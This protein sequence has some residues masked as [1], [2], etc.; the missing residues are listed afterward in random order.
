[1]SLDDIVVVPFSSYLWIVHK[2]TN[3]LLYDTSFRKKEGSILYWESYAYWS[4]TSMR[5]VFSKQ[6][7][8]AMSIQVKDW[9]NLNCNGG[10]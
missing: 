8:D 6:P 4:T 10:F 5:T 3:I 2:E 1:M 9:L 7:L